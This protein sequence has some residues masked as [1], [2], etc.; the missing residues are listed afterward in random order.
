MTVRNAKRGPAPA[1]LRADLTALPADQ[2][3]LY[4]VDRVS[5]ALE[6]AARTHP[7][8]AV[9]SPEATWVG[10]R[11]LGS[12]SA[13]ER[14]R[15][16]TKGPRPYGRF[17]VA[18]ILLSGRRF[19]QRALAEQL[20][21]T[22]PAVSYALEQLGDLAIRTRD[23]W[24]TTDPEALFLVAMDDYPGA[25]G[26]TTH[27]WH[28]AA[29]ERQ[30]EIIAGTANV[31]LSGDLAARRISAWRVPE[32]V[33]LYTEGEVAPDRLGFALATP[34]DYTLELTIPADRSISRTAAAFDRPGIADPVIVARDIRRTG[35]TGDEAE[36]ADAVMR[37]VT[38]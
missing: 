5:P 38:S 15:P 8:L 7:Q 3:V 16:S 6:A 36:A 20:G 12:A 31:L 4:V 17:A 34:N 14:A 9:V 22:Q 1:A 21:I 29:L 27:W 13:P 33:V 25:G 2:L 11:D 37:T 26:I 18:R 23:G 19:T 10:G 32:H 28:D 35:T 30:Y 24:E